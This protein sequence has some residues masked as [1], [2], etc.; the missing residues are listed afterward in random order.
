[1]SREDAR[2]PRGHIRVGD[3]FELDLFPGVPWGG[4]SPR[5]LT[6]VGSGLFSRQE[7]PGHE[8][9]M[10]P[11]QLELIPGGKVAIRDLVLP[12][13]VG[14]P[15]LLPLRHRAKQFRGRY[16]RLRRAEDG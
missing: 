6:R 1:M 16:R 14:A 13:A 3:Q 11:A 8:V 12:P 9:E 10:D 5:S 7:P 15:S 4:R 2:G